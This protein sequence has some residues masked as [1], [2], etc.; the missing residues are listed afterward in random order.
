MDENKERLQK[1]LC[2][3]QRHLIKGEYT[4]LC[5]NEETTQGIISIIKA[6]E[7]GYQ[8]IRLEQF[9]D[10]INALAEIS[11]HNDGNNEEYLKALEDVAEELRKAI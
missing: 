2:S 6:L 5:D 7:N 8:L 10:A 1:E 9:I 11:V 3:A 4:I